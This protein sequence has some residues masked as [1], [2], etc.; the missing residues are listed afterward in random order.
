MS[1][2]VRILRFIFASCI[3]QTLGFAPRQSSSNLAMGKQSH[4]YYYHEMP[5]RQ[6]FHHSSTVLPKKSSLIALRMAPSPEEQKRPTRKKISR[7][8]NLPPSK[9]NNWKSQNR[10]I[11]RNVSRKNSTSYITS[12]V[13]VFGIISALIMLWSEASIAVTRCG[14]VLLPDSVEK[15]SYISVFVLASG[16]NLSRIIFGSGMSNLIPVGDDEKRLF[17]FMEAAVFFSILG[18]FGVL[19]LQVSNSDAF[20][21]G[22]CMTGIDVRRCQLMNEV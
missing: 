3:F 16:S 5:M 22:A 11:N 1:Y 4:L 20:A 17:R 8:D 21:D 9:S 13:A 12:A 14:P 6:F 10:S 7:T 2:P 15:S 19:G 18:A